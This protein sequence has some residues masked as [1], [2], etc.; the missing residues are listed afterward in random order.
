MITQNFYNNPR[1]YMFNNFELIILG[2]VTMIFIAITILLALKFVSNYIRVRKKQLL[3]GG[4]TYFGLASLWFGVGLNFIMVMFFDVIPPMEIHFLFH[5]GLATIAQWFFLILCLDLSHLKSAT[6]KQLKII[7]GIIAIIVEIL[8]IILAFTNNTGLGT[9]IAP[10]QV[11][12]GPISYVYLGLH[13]VMFVSLGLWFGLQSMKS[14]DKKLKL[15]GK[16]II[17]SFFLILSASGVE[18]FFSQI[19]MFIFGRIL[20]TFSAIFFYGGFTLPKWMERIFLR[21]G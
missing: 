11:V 17:L 13:A 20:A 9:L 4:I 10:I 21:K 12:Y 2:I 1:D 3:Y 14:E 15:K 5:G 18:I 6:K 8:Y 16:L 19:P 7:S